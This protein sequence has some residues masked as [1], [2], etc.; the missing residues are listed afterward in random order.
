MVLPRGEGEIPSPLGVDFKISDKHLR[1]FHLGVPPGGSLAS[2]SSSFFCIRERRELAVYM[3]G[4][5]GPTY[6]LG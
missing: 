4:E 1:L 3:R 5:E 2:Y 6:F